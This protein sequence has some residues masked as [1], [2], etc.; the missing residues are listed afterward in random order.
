MPI[1]MTPKRAAKIKARGDA[2]ARKEQRSKDAAKKRAEQRA[3]VLSRKN[4]RLQRCS[5]VGKLIRS[6]REAKDISQ[7]DAAERIGISNVFLGRIELGKCDLPLKHVAAVAKILCI[8]KNDLIFAIKHDINN[9]ID[10]K[11]SNG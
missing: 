6:Q 1:A 5:T 11:A 7:V 3:S 9:R 2:A 8:P 10:R 4:A